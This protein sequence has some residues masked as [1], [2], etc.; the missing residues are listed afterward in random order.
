M[1][2]LFHT[3][4]IKSVLENNL[5]QHEQNKKMAIFIVISIDVYK[6]LTNFQCSLIRTNFGTLRLKRSFLNV[7][8]YEKIIFYSEIL[9][10]F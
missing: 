6:Y 4:N 3:Y 10:S 9:N 7:M 2:V 1:W 8:E 5:V